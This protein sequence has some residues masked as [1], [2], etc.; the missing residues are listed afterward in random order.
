MYS[1][2][3]V[4]EKHLVSGDVHLLQ[5]SGTHRRSR[6]QSSPEV[7]LTGPDAASSHAEDGPW[8]VAY[9]WQG[10]VAGTDSVSQALER[11]E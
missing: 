7:G 1:D 2:R 10:H 5:H 9:V 11:A 8:E 6:H 3:T 4:S